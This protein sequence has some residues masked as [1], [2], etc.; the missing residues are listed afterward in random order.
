M[1]QD[2]PSALP[3]AEEADIPPEVLLREQLPPPR[4]RRRARIGCVIGLF[5]LLGALAL[6]WVAWSN[7]WVT[8]TRRGGIEGPPLVIGPTA[9]NIAAG[10]ILGGKDVSDR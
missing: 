1:G 5:I 8:L 10:L 4:R 2:A 9:T 6:L 3:G 7:G